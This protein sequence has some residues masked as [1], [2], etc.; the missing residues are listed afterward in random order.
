MQGEGSR[1]HPLDVQ[2]LEEGMSSPPYAV[3]SLLASMLSDPLEPR[4][5]FR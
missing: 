1:E 3:P 4:R 2:R 5:V